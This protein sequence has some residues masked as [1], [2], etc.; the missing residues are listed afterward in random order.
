MLITSFWGPKLGPDTLRW[1]LPGAAVLPSPHRGAQAWKT[2]QGSPPFGLEAPSRGLAQ[3]V[4]QC[5]T[6]TGPELGLGLRQRDALSLA[7]WE[8]REVFQL[9]ADSEMLLG[10]R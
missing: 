1:K 7:A 6:G 8:W 10:E 3:P 4:G 2:F 5:Q 9:G